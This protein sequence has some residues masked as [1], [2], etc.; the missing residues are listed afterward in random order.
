MSLKYSVVSSLIWKFLE[1]IGSRGAQFIV[2]IVLVLLLPP[3]DFGLI[4]LAVVFVAIANVFVQ[5]CLNTALIQKKNANNLDFLIVFYSCLTLA[6]A[7][8]R[9]CLEVLV[10]MPGLLDKNYEGI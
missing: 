6:T 8:F 5:S 3:A 1:R 10:G 2:A 4:A 9:F 7:L